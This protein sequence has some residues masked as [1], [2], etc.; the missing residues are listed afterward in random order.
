MEIVIA[1]PW[2]NLAFLM[3]AKVS[4]AFICYVIDEDNIPVLQDLVNRRKFQLALYPSN[5]GLNLASE[6]QQ[7]QHPDLGVLN[8]CL[9]IIY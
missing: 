5:T 7:N 3:S 1:Y 4:S 6:S 2:T 9:R 8:H